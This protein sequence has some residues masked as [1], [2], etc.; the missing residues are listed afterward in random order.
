MTD[1]LAGSVY[2]AICSNTCLEYPR[3]SQQAVEAA[4]TDLQQICD[5]STQINVM[6]LEEETIDTAAFDSAG[7]ICS[8]QQFTVFFGPAAVA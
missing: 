7:V 6:A 8:A 4:R 2:L 1:A 3:A 5:G